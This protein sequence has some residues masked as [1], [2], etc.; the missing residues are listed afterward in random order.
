MPSC[1][2]FAIA[3]RFLC[4]AQEQTPDPAKLTLDRIFATDEFHG[5]RVAAV[6]WLEGG[7]YTSL[8]PSK[9]NKN[10]SDIVRYDATGKSEVL[11]AAEKLV[12]PKAKDALAVEGYELSKDLDVVLIFTNSRKVW[13]QHTRGDYWIFQRS[14]GKLTK[15]GGDAK[16]ST[17]MFAKL[18]PDGTRVGY[19]CG[20]NV[21]VEPVTGG[22]ATK[23]TND[24]SNDV[25]NGTFDWVYEEEFDCRDGWRW[26][27]DGKQ[28]A[29]WQLDTRGVK[30]FT[31]ID[32]MTESY[33]ILKTFAYP[34]TGERNSACRVGVVAAAGG[35]T[36]WLDIPGDTRTDCYIPKMEWAGNSQELMIQRVNRLQN[37]VDV[38][39]GDTATGKV[40]KMLTERD[41]AW[42]DIHDDAMPPGSRRAAPSPGSVTA[43]VGG[44]CTSPHAMEQPC[45][46]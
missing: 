27:P 24:G 26:S 9:A 43:T 22:P 38:M 28:I 23:L 44:I 14:T 17:L 40:Q 45:G 42:V 34:K 8:Q 36:R 33:P 6:H 1:A 4:A 10:V 7:A 12:P 25:I 2:T 46:A 30:T 29:Y 41:G 18:S 31:L 19:V 3:D 11:V 39:L 37:A 21:F 16:P 20:N 15:V 35:T 5:E 13:R 32:N